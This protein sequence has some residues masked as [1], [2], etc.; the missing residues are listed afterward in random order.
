MGPRV[1][2][3]HDRQTSSN[4]RFLQDRGQVLATPMDSLEPLAWDSVPL[5]LLECSTCSGTP[6]VLPSRDRH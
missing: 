1:F 5:Q 2:T 6:I 3:E 4:N